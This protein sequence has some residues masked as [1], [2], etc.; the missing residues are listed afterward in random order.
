MGE[1]IELPTAA[2]VEAITDLNALIALRDEVD[3]VVTRIE[4]TLQNTQDDVD[5][6]RHRAIGALTAHRHA[7]KLL[8]A[9]IKTLRRQSG[10]KPIKGVAH[11][12]P[13][14]DNDPLTNEVLA[15]RPQIDPE[16]ISTVVEIDRHVAWLAERIV[17]VEND[18]NDE[19]GFPSG[20]RDEGFLAATNTLIRAM[21]SLRSALQVRRGVISRADRV[22]K[23]AE[24]NSGR[25]RMFID[26][27][28]ELLPRETYQ[29]IWTRVERLE[30]E[31]SGIE[32]AA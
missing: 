16:G 15:R 30:I 19:I 14:G 25:E 3:L 28:R 23:T 27:A 24:Q 26:A 1:R 17:A 13:A 8:W 20:Q 9:R 32:R 22:A 7:S 29:A 12:R 11:V 5:G 21:K 10:P 31:A 18:R 4:T 6:W 2:Q